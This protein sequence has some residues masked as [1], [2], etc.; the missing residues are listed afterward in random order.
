MNTAEAMAAMRVSSRDGSGRL[1]SRS[2]A[3]VHPVTTADGGPA[4]LKVGTNRAELDFYRS[5]TVPVR[6]PRLLDHRDST[7]LLSAA[8]TTVDVTQWTTPM[9]ADLLGALAALH[10]TPPPPWDAPDPLAEA[11]AQ[12]DIALIRDFWGT[13][14]EVEPLQAARRVFIHGDCHTENITVDDGTLVFC[15]WQSTGAGRASS[16]LALLSVR[17]T[18]AGVRVP[19]EL[20]PADDALRRA[21]R[22]EE[23]AMLVFLW[24]Q[25]ARYNTPE[26]N[27]RI[28]A[29]GRLLAA[30][31]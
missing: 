31:A 2:G 29:R 15:D 21:I 14:P 3:G 9:W 22:A 24:P 20:Y 10:A 7:L 30:D 13:P 28:R 26:G 18:P 4:F 11:M 17:A 1:E 19:L 12:P 5:L 16:D 23:L 8:G 27:D 6:T 25:Y